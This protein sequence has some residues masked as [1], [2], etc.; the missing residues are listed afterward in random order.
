MATEI[1][2]FNQS[3][4]EEDDVFLLDVWDQVGSRAWGLPSSNLNPQG[5]KAWEAGGLSEHPCFPGTEL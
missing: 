2:D 1:P 4:L 5:Q 3:A